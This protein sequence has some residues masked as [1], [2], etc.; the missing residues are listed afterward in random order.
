MLPSEE[1]LTGL[2]FESDLTKYAGEALVSEHFNQRALV[3]DL[4]TLQ[5]NNY[6]ND[7]VSDMLRPG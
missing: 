2:V 1:R 3:Q 4:R 7:T 6:L 5:G